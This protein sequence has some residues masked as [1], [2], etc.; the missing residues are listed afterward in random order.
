[1]GENRRGALTTVVCGLTLVVAASVGGFSAEA[2]APAPAEFAECAVRTVW[3]GPG[4]SLVASLSRDGQLLAFVDWDTGDLAVRDMATGATR[5][6]T[7]KGSWAVSQESALTSAIS[8]D[9]SRVAY[10]W[11]NSQ[12]RYELRVIGTDGSRPETIHTSDTADVFPV[13]WLPG[14]SELVFA[15][16]RPDGAIAIALMRVADRTIRVIK[17]FDPHPTWD[18]RL[19]PDGR[20]IAYD[21][22]V[23]RDAPDRD[24][25][26]LAVDG[27]RDVP[28]VEG[29]SDDAVV[30]WSLD[31]NSVLFARASG[32]TSD[33]WAVDVKAE[34]RIPRLVKRDLGEVGSLSFV[35]GGL[36]YVFGR[37][38]RKVNTATLDPATGRASGEPVA[39]QRSTEAASFGPEWS[40]D[41]RSLAYFSTRGS[42]DIGPG[43]RAIVIRTMATGEE[44][45]VPVSLDYPTGHKYLI[46]WSGDGR[47]V[48]T[49]GNNEGGR[50]TV[51]RIDIR[52]GGMEAVASAEPRAALVWFALTP[53]TIFYAEQ[54]AAPALFRVARRELGSA[55]QKELYRA[56]LPPRL[57]D[58]GA[59]GSYYSAA[60]SPDGK[61]L[62]VSGPGTTANSNVLLIL[63]REGGEPVRLGA[64]L[65]EFVKIQTWTADGRSLL[66]TNRPDQ[67]SRSE[68]WRIPVESGEAQPSGL[69][70]QALGLYGFSLHPDGRRVAF[71]TGQI[72]RNEVRVVEGCSWSAP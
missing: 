3:E 36:Y 66:V 64:S 57:T 69:A 72:A 25:R 46:R 52:T 39:M 26:L 41:G 2:Q 50:E 13:D 1:M 37:G 27:T 60:L 15:L 42:G 5:R 49:V 59:R 10:S 4:G 24:V 47:S 65:Q 38:M 34:R 21:Y 53:R 7:N 19:S 18:H 70:L 32:H 22:R 28:L 35:A 11:R 62:A 40:P 6:L 48:F 8:P 58:A 16:L 61:R 31:G 29:P 55:Q 63:P 44:R 33:L 56:G 9:G 54:D 20:T 45:E 71:S 51:Y 30:G 68:V 12:R 67:V 17:G 23:R 43:S 14:G